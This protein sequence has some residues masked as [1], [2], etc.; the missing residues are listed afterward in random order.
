MQSNITFPFASNEH[1]RLREVREVVDPEQR[2]DRF[3]Q[4]IAE[5][6]SN[7]FGTPS[8]LVSVV[9][10]DHQWFLAKT[11]ID[12]ETM[13]RDY[14][15]CSRAIMSDQ[16]L[17]LP[18]TLEHPE[19]ANHPAVMLSPKVRFFVG[20]PIIL[21]SGFRVGCVCAI[22]VSPHD[23]PSQEAI[24]ELQELADQ[25]VTHLERQHAS[26]SGGSQSRRDQIVN[27]ARQD[28]LALVGHEFRTPLTVLLGNAKLLAGY[29]SGEVH[30]EPQ[31]RDEFTHRSLAAIVSSGDH[32]HR[33]IERVIHFAN[34]QN[35]ELFLAEE[36]IPCSDFLQSV[37]EPVEP[38]VIA[39]QRTVETR[40]SDEVPAIHGDGEQLL[41]ALSSL[42]V[43]AAKHGEGDI[44]LFAGLG[45]GHKLRLTCADQGPGCSEEQIKRSGQPFSVGGDLDRRSVSGLG[46]GL[47]LANKIAELHGGMLQTGKDTKQS[48]VEIVLP[49]WRC[50]ALAR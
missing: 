33:L 28:F 22:D 50:G 29:F 19:F 2:G 49:G 4:K 44:E 8:S 7:L 41:L 39:E 6:V 17:I 13:P 38:V 35:G 30:I 31:Q 12:L 11:G 3:V 37:V 46:L 21:S 16:P 24:Q 47:P 14:S 1:A 43:N 9:E 45:E 15:I 36:T 48:W 10:S 40:C 5:R 42:V 32:L 23:T 20:A 34:L 18:D 26:R 25:V 27:D